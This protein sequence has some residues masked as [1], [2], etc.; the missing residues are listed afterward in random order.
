MQYLKLKRDRFLPRPSHFIS[1][2]AADS[3]VTH[4]T[5]TR[6]Y[7]ELRRYAVRYLRRVSSKYL[8][9]RLVISV[10]PQAKSSRIKLLA[11]LLTL[12]FSNT[13]AR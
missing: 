11:K 13:A 7:R 8:S 12:L 9:T 6:T 4:T 1:Q 3:V 2:P 10:P 5:N